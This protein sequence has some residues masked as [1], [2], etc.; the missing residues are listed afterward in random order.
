[1]GEAQVL[2]FGNPR[3]GTPAMV[4]APLVALELP[5]RALVWE[6]PSGDCRVSYLDPAA[7]ARRFG[8]PDEAA[9]GLRAMDDLVAASLAG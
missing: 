3:A 5:L 9:A 4:A 6:D 7:L 1:M 2:V 8:V